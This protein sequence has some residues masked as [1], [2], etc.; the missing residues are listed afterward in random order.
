MSIQIYKWLCVYYGY[1]NK[2]RITFLNTK[3]LTL[4]SPKEYLHRT[5]IEG[6][7]THANHNSGKIART[8]WYREKYIDDS[9]IIS[10]TT[11]IIAILFIVVFVMSIVLIMIIIFFSSSIKSTSLYSWN[12][13][14]MMTSSNGNISALLAICPRNSP[15][16]GIHRS[17]V[18]PPHK[19]QWRR[20]LMFSLICVWITGWV[21]NREA[22][23]Q[24]RYRVHYDVIVMNPLSARCSDN[25]Y[26]IKHCE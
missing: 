8:K 14:N 7:I 3:E 1:V 25:P 4:K 11:V 26:A 15:A 19:G 6:Y 10:I 5:T 9:I 23:D 16:R 13:Q 21:N 17:P 20:A 12:S 2:G 24:R 18:N 22:G